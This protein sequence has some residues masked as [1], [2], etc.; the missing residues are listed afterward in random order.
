MAS[1]APEPLKGFQPEL[2]KYFPQSGH[3]KT[4]FWSLAFNGQGPRNGDRSSSI[5]IDRSPS[6]VLVDNS[7]L[8]WTNSDGKNTFEQDY[9]SIE[10]RPPANRINMLFCSPVTLTLIYGLDLDN[11]KIYLHTKNK[12]YRLRSRSNVRALQREIHLR[13]KT[14]P[15]SICGC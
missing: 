13:L 6:T 4:R 7:S 2:H 8:Q 10:G 14:L 11:L 1:W 12:F 9:L 3:E 5:P 15:H